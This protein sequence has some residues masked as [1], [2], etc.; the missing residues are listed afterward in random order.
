MSSTCPCGSVVEHTLGKG[1]VTSSILVTGFG[2]ENIYDKAFGS[3][4]HLLK[5]PLSYNLNLGQKKLFAFNHRT[6]WISLE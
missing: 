3:S 4:R 5:V 2:L 6:A 1:E